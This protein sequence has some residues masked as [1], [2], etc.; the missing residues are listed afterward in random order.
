MKAD[1]LDEL[2]ELA[3]VIDSLWEN[4]FFWQMPLKWAH[5][6][7]AWYP[8]RVRFDQEGMVTHAYLN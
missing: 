6:H 1:E 5:E 8:R 2:Y 7:A 4:W 3:P